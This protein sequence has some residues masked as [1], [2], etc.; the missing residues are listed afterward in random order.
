MPQSMSSVGLK[1]NGVIQRLWFFVRPF[2][3]LLPITLDL[4]G[5]HLLPQSNAQ[6]PDLKCDY[7]DPAMPLPDAEVEAGM[8]PSTPRLFQREDSD[9]LVELLIFDNL[10]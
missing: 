5:A 6:D 3:S 8:V 7:L 2:I 9:V 1:M 10:F 4:F